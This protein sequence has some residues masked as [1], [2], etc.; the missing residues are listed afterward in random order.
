MK[1]QCAV[2]ELLLDAVCP[3][4]MPWLSRLAKP[5]YDTLKALCLN[6]HRERGFTESIVLPAFKQL[7]Y[8]AAVVDDKFKEEHELDPRTTPS[9]AT[10][11]VILN[12][13]R[14]M[15]RHVGLGIELKLYPNYY[16]LSTAI[17]YR[18]FLLSAMINVRGTIEQERIERKKMDLRIKVEEEEAERKAKAEA[19]QQSKKRG[20]GKKGNKSKQ[21]KPEPA[22]PA[23]DAEL[24][25]KLAEDLEDRIEYT[26]LMLRRSMCRGLVR[27]IAAL[28]QAKLLPD[29]P[30]TTTMFTTHEKIF[31]RRFEAFSSLPQPP[32]LSYEDYVRGSDFSA[33]QSEDLLFSATECFRAGKSIVDSLLDVIVTEGCDDNTINGAKRKDDDLYVPIRREE[34]MA[35][36]KVCVTNSLFL[37]KLSSAGDGQASDGKVAVEF[38]AHKQYCT[39]SIT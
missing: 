8:V 10:N 38:K 36:A 21:S 31:E 3:D 35:L 22:A 5:M 17:W 1:Q 20:K 9:Y 39:F 19:Q 12:T 15:E 2:P 7:Q 28:R 34:I 30:A 4:G 27:Y 25:R 29:P 11:Y 24:G 16:D 18:D 14:L 6:R 33:V 26:T 23:P 13:I 37:H 32:P